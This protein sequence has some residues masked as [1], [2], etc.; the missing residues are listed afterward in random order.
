M[1]GRDEA[2]GVAT[3]PRSGRPSAGSSRLV[4]VPAETGAVVAVAGGLALLALLLRLPGLQQSLFGDELFAVNEV[5]GRSFSGML[6]AIH[7]S[8]EVTPPLFFGLAWLSVHAFAGLEAVRAPSL[9]LGTAV[10]PLAFLLGRR[11]AGTAAGAVGALLLALSPFAIFYS[12]EARPYATVM[13]LVCL[14]TFALL[15]A[16]DGRTAWWIV[17]ALA[18]TAAIYT[19]YT[20]VFALAA[21]TLWAA[22]CFR[23]RW[24]WLGGA[25]LTAGILY[26]PWLPWVSDKHQ[27]AIYGPFELGTLPRSLVQA[28]P[29]HPFAVPR[30]LPGVG[31]L[32]VLLVALAAAAAAASVVSARRGGWPRIRPAS[33]LVLLVLLA[34]ATPTGLVLYSAA[35]GDNLLL[36]RNLSASVPALALLAGAVLAAPPRWFAAALAGVAVAAVATGTVK[37]LGDGFRRPDTKAAAALIDAESTPRTPVIDLQL[38]D[39]SNPTAHALTIALRRPHRLF[40]TKQRD[41]AWRSAS[42]LH[43][44]VFVAW[45]DASAFGSLA[46]VAGPP[47]RFRARFRLV[48]QWRWPGIFPVFVRRY[49]PL[50]NRADQGP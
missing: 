34:F 41:A 19:H 18:L 1:I 22:W 50:S 11:I 37:A 25:T 9:V 29:G 42:R 14:S 45:T 30:V 46:A 24:L 17:Y 3:G 5:V 6:G 20:V 7:S 2:T 8:P 10:V 39:P 36:P 16:L 4:G 26:A 31:A 48:G 13:F 21:Q 38:V 49:E 15:E 12:A 32:V 43:E 33:P 35:S 23:D 28:F 47:P 40:T 27:L 44:S